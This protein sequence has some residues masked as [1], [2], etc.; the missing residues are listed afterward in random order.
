MSFLK[1]QFDILVSSS[2]LLG[3]LNR[4]ADGSTFSIQMENNGLDI[5]RNAQ[6]V[7]LSVI[8]AELWYNSSNVEDGKNN[9]F[10]FKYG[11]TAGA[12]ISYTVE[13]P[14]GLYKADDIQEALYREMLNKYGTDVNIQ[15]MVSAKRIQISPDES[16]GKI[17]VSLGIDVAGGNTYGLE[18]DFSQPRSIGLLLGFT[19][20]I[21]ATVAPNIVD[22]F[23]SDT[24]PKFNAFNYYLIS[25]DMVN[26]GIQI[27]STYSQIISKV[28]ITTKPNT[29]V[30]YSP[31]NPTL[32]DAQSLAGDNRR[33]YTFR[34]LDD[35]LQSVHTKGEYYSVQLRISYFEPVNFNLIG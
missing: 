24:D 13:L 19:T 12:A 26:R 31:S 10:T 5:P 20:N 17:L 29:Q 23:F 30:L 34:L 4:S 7:N 9:E 16:Q 14:T 15:S 1:R 25:S 27:G 32:I 22:D 2:P 33:Y 18:V 21:V 28:L 6:N 3:A 11:A 8:G 35:A